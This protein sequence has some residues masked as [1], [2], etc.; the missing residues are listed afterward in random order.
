MKTQT[1]APYILLLHSLLLS[2]FL[3]CQAPT[4]EEVVEEK[5]TT[6]NTQLPEKKEQTDTNKQEVDAK[7]FVYGIDISKF[8]GDEMTFIKQKADSIAFVIS[9]ASEGIT[10]VDPKFQQ[11]WALIAENNLIRGSYHFYRTRDEPVAQANHYLKTI[12][13]LKSNDFPP[14]IDFES[15]GIDTTQ[16]VEQI[17]RDLLTCLKTI[18]KKSAR[19]PIIYCNVSDGNKYLNNKAFAD[20]PLWIASYV[21]KDQPNLPKNWKSKGWA[22]WQKLDHY[23]IGETKNDFDVFNGNLQELKAFIEQH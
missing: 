19:K 23:S 16:S 11:N 14:I 15:G 20:Y 9:K 3:A 7:P 17:Q 10:Y 1:N 5:Q 2:M 4:T 12:A 13:D 6:Q 22:I 18:E 21:Q 8:Q